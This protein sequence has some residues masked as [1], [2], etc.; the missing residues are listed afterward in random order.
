MPAFFRELDY[1]QTSLGELVLRKRSSPALG[2]RM[3][4]E[5]KLN[6]EFLMSSAVNAS[7]VA[8][9]DLALA[10]LGEGPAE[11]LVGGLGLGCTAEAVLKHPRVRRLDVVE[12][13]EPVIDWHRR[14]LVPAA[15]TLMDDP[16]C[17][18]VEAD[19]Y[20]Y[21]ADADA[22]PDRRWDAILLDIDHSP[23]ARLDASHAAFYTDIRLRELSGHLRLGGVF[24]LWSFEP[25]QP[26]FLDL[27]RGAF[28]EVHTHEIR[29]HNPMTDEDETNTIVLASRSSKKS[30]SM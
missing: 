10:L 25:A 9:A 5:V 7:E 22:H 2:G 12:C 21:V 16:R 11:V 26:E 1:R 23:S 14:R 4:Y 8:L 13:L 28:D 6:D 17:R 19:F 15:D 24:G 3:V 20:A 18:L 29:F 27:L 30:T